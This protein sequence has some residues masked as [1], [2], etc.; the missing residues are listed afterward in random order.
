[1]DFDKVLFQQRSA[2]TAYWYLHHPTRNINHRLH[3]TSLF[4]MLPTYVE[5]GSHEVIARSYY[6]ETLPK[7][8]EWTSGTNIVFVCYPLLKEANI[9]FNLICFDVILIIHTSLENSPKSHNPG[10]SLQLHLYGGV[11]PHYWKID[12]YAV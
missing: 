7:S 9:H 2:K 12:P 10:E 5:N 4:F 8:M 1:M 3:E 6:D 11:R